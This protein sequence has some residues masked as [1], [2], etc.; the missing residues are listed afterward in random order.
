VS[1]LL[2]PALV[3]VVWIA[4]WGNLSWANVASGVLVVGLI[5]LIIRPVPRQHQVHPI[6]MTKLV[7]IFFWRLITSSVIVVRTVLAPTPERLVSG[8]V[9]VRLQHPSRLVATVVADAISLTPGTLTLEATGEPP[10][11]YIHVL[12]ID[13]PEAVR[14]DVRGLEQLVLAA[15]TP[16][17]DEVTA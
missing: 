3:F 4:L 7:L 9:A 6:A 16:V 2:A 17:G 5:G 8:V 15:V 11:L 1:R 14:E 12:G 10:V 13:D